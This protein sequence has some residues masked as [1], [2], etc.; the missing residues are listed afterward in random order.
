M[1]TWNVAVWVL[2]ATFA[3]TLVVLITAFLYLRE[4]RIR[5]F[6]SESRKE[7][8][9]NVRVQPQ[10]SLEEALLRVEPPISTVRHYN[11]KV[12][13]QTQQKMKP[14][15]TAARGHISRVEKY[16]EAIRRYRQG[17]DRTEI[18]KSL[19]ISFLELDMLGQLQ[20]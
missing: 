1:N 9:T 2:D 18:E 15:A 10:R 12:R 16:L 19:G 13:Y 14:A 20:Q 5:R 3:V 8:T 7:T 11:P 17:E 4:K 6:I